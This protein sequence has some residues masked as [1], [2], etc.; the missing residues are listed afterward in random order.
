[1]GGDSGSSFQEAA[2]KQSEYRRPEQPEEIY[3]RQ[4]HRSRTDSGEDFSALL[5]TG[6][7]FGFGGL[8]LQSFLVS[9]TLCLALHPAL[10]SALGIPLPLRLLSL[11]LCHS[12]LRTHGDCPCRCHVETVPYAFF[13]L[14][15]DHPHCIRIRDYRGTVLNLFFGLFDFSLCDLTHLAHCGQHHFHSIGFLYLGESRLL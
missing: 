15:N 11:S 7:G 13:I 4:R 12:D 3:H 5:L 8:A 14:K 6:V 10:T 1:M 9:H 2:T